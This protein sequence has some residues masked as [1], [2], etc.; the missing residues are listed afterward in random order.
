MIAVP[1]QGHVHRKGHN[2]QRVICQIQKRCF[3]NEDARLLGRP[4]FLIMILTLE[5]ALHMNGGGGREMTTANGLSPLP[6]H[7]LEGVG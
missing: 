1:P 7:F 4:L 3:L 5:R 2:A 6:L